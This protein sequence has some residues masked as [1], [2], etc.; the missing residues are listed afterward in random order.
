M[1]SSARRALKILAAVGEPGRP[2]GVTEIARALGIAP[3]TA[4]SQLARARAAARALIELPLAGR[5]RRPS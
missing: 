4:K 1:S 2:M 5:E 3:G